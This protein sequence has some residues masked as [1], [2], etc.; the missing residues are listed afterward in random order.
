MHD[1]EDDDDDWRSCKSG[2]KQL[3]FEQSNILLFMGFCML[4]NN[5]MVMQ[6][7]HDVMQENM[8][9]VSCLFF[10]LAHFSIPCK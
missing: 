7:I 1:D 5:L 3:G 8:Y 10:W 4:C 9:F 6:R 2:L